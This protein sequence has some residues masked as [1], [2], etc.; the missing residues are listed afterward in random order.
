[1]FWVPPNVSEESYKMG[2][3]PHPNHVVVPTPS[4]NGVTHL[5]KM[6]SETYPNHVMALTS[7]ENGVAYVLGT[8]ECVKKTLTKETYIFEK[9]PTKETCIFA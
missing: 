3:E 9:R 8:P 5:V 1:M 2:S 7:S 6:G 4:D